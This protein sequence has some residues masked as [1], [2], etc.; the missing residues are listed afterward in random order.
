[1][2]LL[3]AHRRINAKE[4]ANLLGCARKTVLNGKGGTSV[5]TRIRNGSQVRFL[6]EEVLDLMR[7]QEQ[8][9]NLSVRDLQSDNRN[10]QP[11]PTTL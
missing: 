5:L 8:N 3:P 7:K 6:L 9:K 2:S 1:M 11:Y 4:V 10:G